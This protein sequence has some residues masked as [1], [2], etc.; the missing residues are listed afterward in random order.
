MSTSAITT[1]TGLTSDLG[2]TLLAVE[3]R[4]QRLRMV[5]TLF[6]C[7]DSVGCITAIQL[8]PNKS[9]AVNWTRSPPCYQGRREIHAWILVVRSSLGRSERSKTTLCEALLV[10][11]RASC[12]EKSAAFSF[13]EPQVY[14]GCIDSS[15]QRC[16]LLADAISADHSRIAGGNEG[17]DLNFP[18]CTH[19]G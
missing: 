18:L 12:I 16:Q 7:R 3:S 4:R 5:T 1:R 17:T 11:E 9:A 10:K 2:R 19:S 13:D 6:L 14:D 8:R 15:A